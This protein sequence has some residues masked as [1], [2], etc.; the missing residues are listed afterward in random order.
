[1]RVPIIAAAMLLCLG[2]AAHAQP[3]PPELLHLARLHGVFVNA[4]G[5]PIAN[6]VITLVQNQK[7]AYSAKTDASGKF[8][9]RHVSGRYR[10]QMRSPGYSPVNRDVIVGLEAFMYLRSSMIYIIAG[11]GAC[12]DDCA[13]V[14]TD[15]STFNQQLK[16]DAGHYD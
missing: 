15:K 11:P 2:I 13:S 14:F 10:L 1:M 7:V 9:I 6:A 8:E 3:D 16:H 4:K 5:K 12:T